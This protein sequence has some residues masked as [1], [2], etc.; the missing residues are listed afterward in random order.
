[1]AIT[2][3]VI[4]TPSNEVLFTDSILGNAVDAV[5]ASSCKI[6]YVTLDN[7][8][9]VAASYFKAFNLA[10][11]SVTLGT[12]APD[13][14]ILVPAS[15]I[16]TVPFFT[17]AAPGLTF[18]TALSIACVTAAGTAGTTSPSSAVTCTISYV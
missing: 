3:I 12:T 1:M 17:G 18:S 15:S 6:F 8:L 2:Q 10:S 13:M 16:I 11:A 7:S 4:Q 5:K 9:N 14:V